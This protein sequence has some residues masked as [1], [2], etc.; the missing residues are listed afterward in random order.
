MHIDQLNYELM[1]RDLQDGYT[2]IRA[3]LPM[4][5]REI[6]RHA[7]PM[8]TSSRN[9]DGIVTNTQVPVPTEDDRAQTF[10]I[11]G[12]VNVGDKV[13]VSND[14]RVDVATV[15]QVDP[16]PNFDRERDEGRKID[17]VVCRVDFTEYNNQIAKE[18]ELIKYLRELEI[19]RVKI[20][21]NKHRIGLRQHLRSES[22]DV[23]GVAHPQGMKFNKA[24]RN[25]NKRA[26]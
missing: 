15:I 23:Y 26:K 13:I 11:R 16:V 3:V 21:R 5:A 9:P 7:N 25:F 24:L 19:E 8:W 1:L 4:S 2:T 10:K 20:G 22:G 12:E 18:E 17:W 14:G 6:E